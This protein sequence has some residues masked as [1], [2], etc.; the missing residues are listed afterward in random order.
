MMIAKFYKRQVGRNAEQLHYG[1]TI[2]DQDSRAAT[3]GTTARL[4]TGLGD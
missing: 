4:D 1:R 3:E 2:S